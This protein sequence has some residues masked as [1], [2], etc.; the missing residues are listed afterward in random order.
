MATILAVVGVIVVYAIAGSSRPA[1]PQSMLVLAVL[2]VAFT[3]GTIAQRYRSW[4]LGDPV[5]LFAAVFAIYNMSVLAEFAISAWGS[6]VQAIFFID[7]YQPLDYFAKAGAASTLAAI[8]MFYAAT[9]LPRWSRA[10]LSQ[11]P[12][13]PVKRP[14]RAERLFR[15]GA[16]SV[17]GYMALTVLIIVATVGIVGFLSAARAGTARLNPSTALGIGIPLLPVA[18]AGIAC[19]FVGVFSFGH[20]RRTITFLVLLV[21]FTLFNFIQGN[22]HLVIYALIMGCGAY[23]TL[24]RPNRRMIGRLAVFVIVAYMVFVFVNGVRALL[25]AF[26]A[27]NVTSAELLERASD[28]SGYWLLPSNNEFGGPYYTLIDEVSYPREPQYGRT[29]LD[30]LL[31]ALPSKLYP[32]EKPPSVAQRFSAGFWERIGVLRGIGFGFSP[33]A[34]A[35]YNFRWVGIAF[36]FALWTVLFHL[37]GY[38]RTRGTAGVLVYL[39]LLAQTVNMN[40]YS[41]DG[42]MQEAAFSVIV[43]YGL[44]LLAISR[45]NVS[46]PT[47]T[48]PLQ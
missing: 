43:V 20:R 26:F 7:A 35:F 39:V 22:R 8:G 21:A 12:L 9:L 34:E 13:S 3:L 14:A 19:M 30:A 38:V 44:Y 15:V 4:G 1:S 18:I 33:V 5:I 36:V 17:L 47:R 31:S 25:P 11:V 2:I 42:V 40:R 28:F 46:Q 48:L 23:F 6:G 45:I 27:G 32:G 10:P 29:Y 41:L 24:A 16:A 37:I